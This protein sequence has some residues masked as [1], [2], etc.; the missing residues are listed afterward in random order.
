MQNAGRI[1]STVCNGMLSSLGI[2][3]PILIG[4]PDNKIPILTGI[5]ENNTFEPFVCDWFHLSADASVYAH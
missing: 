4:T 3:G 5:H 1:P 2:T